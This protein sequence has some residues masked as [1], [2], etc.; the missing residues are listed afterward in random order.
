M[1]CDV[2]KDFYELY[3]IKYYFIVRIQIQSNRGPWYAADQVDSF[4]LGEKES[5]SLTGNVGSSPKQKWWSLHQERISSSSVQ[6]WT[7]RTSSGS[8]PLAPLSRN[9]R[10][11]DPSVFALLPMHSCTVVTGKLWGFWSSILWQSHQI[12]KRETTRSLVMW[13]TP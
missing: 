1:C 12:S 10:C 8:S 4:R 11:F 2:K 7:S 13:V 5:D 9:C 6:L 3:N